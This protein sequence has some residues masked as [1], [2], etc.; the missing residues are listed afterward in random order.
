M[1]R[2]RLIKPGFYKNEQL[3]ECSLLARFIFPGL[4]MLADRRGRLEDRP[5]R[6]KADLLPY[7]DADVGA[8]LDEL[9]ANGL[10]I[11]YEVDG[12]RLVQIVNFEKHQNCHA[13][14]VDS[15][16]PP[17]ACDATTVGKHSLGSAKAVAVIAL[18]VPSPAEALNPNPLTEADTEA[19]NPARAA[20]ASVRADVWT[21]WLRY[22]GKQKADTVALQARHLD[23]WS[24]EG[25]DP[26]AIIE[27]SIRNGWK[28]L[29]AGKGPPS[30]RAGSTLS[31]V[32]QRTAD[33]LSEWLNGTDGP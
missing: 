33:N 28:G 15:V 11:R 21:K 8:L 16:L 7:D 22:K 3:A 26:N 24:A 9:A 31:A 30:R 10:L 32:G 12:A 25:K 29:F 27:E 1:A 13:R 20:P 4:W 19:E 5:K 2:A 17:P 6:L 18:A 23:E 14:E